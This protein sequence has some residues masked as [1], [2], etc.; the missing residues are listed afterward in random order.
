MHIYFQVLQL[1]CSML[2]SRDLFHVPHDPVL[3]E[4]DTRK[5]GECVGGGTT[6]RPVAYR[7]MEFP[8]TTHFTNQRTTTITMTTTSSR[9]SSI[10]TAN[11]ALCDWYRNNIFVLQITSSI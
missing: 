8:T 9:L 2:K 5:H 4:A 11:H 3:E 1:F 7:T 6:R 10:T